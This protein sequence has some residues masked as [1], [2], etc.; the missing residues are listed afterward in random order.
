MPRKRRKLMRNTAYI[1][2]RSAAIRALSKADILRQ[3]PETVC[4]AGPV[5]D[6]DSHAA[7]VYCAVMEGYG[8]NLAP[9]PYILR[10]INF[11][12]PGETLD[13][14]DDRSN[15]ERFAAKYWGNAAVRL[16]PKL[17][18]KLT[19]ESVFVLSGPGWRAECAKTAA[20]R[21]DALTAFTI[22]GKCFLNKW[23]IWRHDFRRLELPL[24]TTMSNN[25]ELEFCAYEW[26]GYL[27]TGSNKHIARGIIG[28]TVDP[29]YVFVEDAGTA[30]KNAAARI[31]KHVLPWLYR[32]G[33]RMSQKGRARFEILAKIENRN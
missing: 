14:M 33:G 29:I 22:T 23:R 21:V 31:E 3:M 11:D 26:K 15:E 18:N 4:A 8:L 19:N 32:P 13:E 17:A 10:N 7:D 9:A 25:E 1:S 6:D 2:P 27:V 28:G 24:C 20:E 12:K 5:S 16:T 30:R